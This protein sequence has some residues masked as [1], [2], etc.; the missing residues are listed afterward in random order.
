MVEDAT[1]LDIPLTTLSD[2]EDVCE[3]IVA[4]RQAGFIWELVRQSE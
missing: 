2:Y 1:I 4:Y 3:I